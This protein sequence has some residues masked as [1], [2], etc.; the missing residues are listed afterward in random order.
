MPNI[1][2]LEGRGRLGQ[3]TDFL[4]QIRPR[5]DGSTAYDKAGKNMVYRSDG[6][7][8]QSTLQIG[9]SQKAMYLQANS[10]RGRG[11]IAIMQVKL[12][13]LELNSIR[14]KIVEKVDKVPNR[15]PML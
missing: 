11:K 12:S 7:S 6:L 13:V 14:R 10:T 15:R 5:S 2:I 1:R 9:K 4:S 8:Q 3:W